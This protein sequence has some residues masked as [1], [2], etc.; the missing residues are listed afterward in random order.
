MNKEENKKRFIDPNF[1]ANVH[2][3][4]SDRKE[5]FVGVK[6]S[7]SPCGSQGLFR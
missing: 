6:A 7:A 2:T 3:R 1:A 4:A 5:S